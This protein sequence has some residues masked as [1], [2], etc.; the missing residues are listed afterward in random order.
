MRNVGQRAVPLP[1]AACVAVALLLSGCT[2]ATPAPTPTTSVS[3][4]PTATPTPTPTGP[5]LQT[6]GSATQNLPYFASIVNAVAAGPQAT[7]GRAYIDALTAGGFDKS[8][9]E[10]TQ[11]LTTVGNQADS[12]QFSVKWKGECLVGQ[13]GP[14]VPGPQTRVLP[15]VPEG[16]CLIG[17]TRPIDW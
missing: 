10:V 13:V 17:Q 15:L 1:I 7:Q 2:G 16:T 14:S 11:D 4:T 6:N 12:I 5:A 9:M 3:N 8:A